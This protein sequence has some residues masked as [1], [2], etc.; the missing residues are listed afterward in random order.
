MSNLFKS[1]VI[2]ETVSMVRD[3]A[4]SKILKCEFW[5]GSSRN[6][7][8]LQNNLLYLSCDVPTGGVRFVLW[9]KMAE[10]QRLS[11]EIRGF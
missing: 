1:A 7:N 5:P 10:L 6:L 4:N 3:R 2:S 8:F 9:L 11:S